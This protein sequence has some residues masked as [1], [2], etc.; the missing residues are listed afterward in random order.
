[1]YFCFGLYE[2]MNYLCVT[3]FRGVLVVYDLGVKD[4]H[5]GHRSR[6]LGC[7]AT[8]EKTFNIVCHKER[9]HGDCPRARAQTRG[10]G[11]GFHQ[12]I[13]ISGD[14]TA[15]ETSQDLLTWV[16]PSLPSMRGTRAFLHRGDSF[17]ARFGARGMPSGHIHSLSGVMAQACRWSLGIY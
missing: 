2:L 14:K 13:S 9:R 5:V 11:T 3:R 12:N 15:T 16:S 8:S 17:Q 6:L 10:L 4:E 7:G 1:M